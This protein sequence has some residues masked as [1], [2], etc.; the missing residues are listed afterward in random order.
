MLMFSSF[1]GVYSSNHQPV[2]EGYTADS[3][4]L[5]GLL[6]YRMKSQRVDTHKPVL[7]MEQREGFEGVGPW[8]T[9]SAGLLGSSRLASR[10]V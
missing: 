8:Y 6:C 9:R 3:L 4:F 5:L 1:L 7:D 2:K 10:M